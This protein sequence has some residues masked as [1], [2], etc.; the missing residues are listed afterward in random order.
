MAPGVQTMIKLP[1]FITRNVLIALILGGVSGI[2]FLAF[3][4]EFDHMT[5]GEAFC[6][7]CHSMELVAEPYRESKHY[8]PTSGVRASC[9][10]CHISRGVFA[11][12]WDHFLGTK[13]LI[14]Q[15]FSSIDYDDP[16]LN[17]LHLP[18]AAFATREHMRGQG[19]DTCKRCHVQEAIVGTRA[20]TLAVHRDETKGK[21]CVDCHINLV[22][23][24]VPEKE[25]F[26]RDAWNR[27]IE[28]EFGLEPGA[29]DKLMAGEE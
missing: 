16:V 1:G 24:A 5:S 18:E 19:S 6:A 21:T 12:T 8:M 4:I 15:V 25:T 2:G 14:S 20:E 10:D 29:A 28:Q 17:A 23:R 9:G 11:A 3:L 13:D 7:S 27:M 22:H 26:K